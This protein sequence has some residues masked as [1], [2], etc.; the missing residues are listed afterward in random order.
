V[1]DP[2]A[3]EISQYDIGPFGAL[4]PKPPATV[5]DGALPAGVAVSPD[6]R[7][8][9]VVNLTGTFVDGTVSQ[10][11]VGPGGALSPKAPATVAT[12]KSPALLVVSPDGRS[13]YVTNQTSDTVSEYNIDRRSGALAPKNPASVAAG[14][15]PFG[16][17]I[18]PRAR[19]RD[20]RCD[21]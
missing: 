18:T 17:A 16:I 4:A 1:T 9:Y 20:D 13:V 14:R 6:G 8:V 10:F 2:I 21:R 12:E 3:G 7:S 15:N 11:D 5:P 19:C